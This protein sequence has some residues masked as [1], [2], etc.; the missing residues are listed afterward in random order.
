[1]YISFGNAVEKTDTIHIFYHSEIFSCIDRHWMFT[2]MSF[3]YLVFPDYA[4]VWTRQLL[5][6]RTKRWASAFLRATGVSSNQRPEMA[7]QPQQQW[8]RK[9]AIFSKCATFEY[10]TEK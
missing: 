5:K 8:E 10:H 7:N 9:R 1:M 4:V 2:L 6:C 3:A